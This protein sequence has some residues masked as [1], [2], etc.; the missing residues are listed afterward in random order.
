MRAGRSS[1]RASRRPAPRGPSAAG[2]RRRRV[3][4][5]AR[6]TSRVPAATAARRC[7]AARSRAAH[8]APPVPRPRRTA[9]RQALHCPR[10]SIHA[11][12]RRSRSTGRARSRRSWAAGASVHPPA[13]GRAVPA[14]PVRTRSGRAAARGRPA[15]AARPKQLPPAAGEQAP[16]G[17]RMQVQPAALDPEAAQVRTDHVRERCGVDAMRL[18]DERACAPQTCR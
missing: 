1:W 16:A 4:L 12:W 8:C 18:H 13:R 6:A 14:E 15:I 11:G 17:G 10:A 2:S 7:R 5:A 3:R 9:P